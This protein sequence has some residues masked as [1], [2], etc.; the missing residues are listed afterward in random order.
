MRSSLPVLAWVLLSTIIL[1]SVWAQG[2]RGR[3]TPT[4]SLSGEGTVK[5]VRLG[6]LQ[7]TIED[8]TDWLVSIPTQLENVVF[9]ATADPQFLQPQMGVRFHATFKKTDKRRKEYR[10]TQPI[11]ALEI[12]TL[13][14][15]SE[16]NVYPDDAQDRRDALFQ[17]EGNEE[18]AQ[19]KIVPKAADELDCLVIGKLLEYKNGTIKVAAGLFVIAAE[20]P[21]TAKV[22]VDVRHCLWVRPGDRVELNARYFPALPGQAE[23][24]QLTITAAQPLTADQK[25]AKGQRRGG[26]DRKLEETHKAS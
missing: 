6:V 14:P 7:V 16:P 19:K 26:R 22:A 3:P 20:L 9:R 21:E 23:G 5:S 17:D 13:R 2:R 12:I 25:A 4:E 11:A 24:Q 18:P 15:G 1:S 10:A 8:G